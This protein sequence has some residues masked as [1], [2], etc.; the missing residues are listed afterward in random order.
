V[1]SGAQKLID[2]L[3]AYGL[4][5]FVPEPELVAFAWEVELGPL[6]GEQIELAFRAP[7]DF[8]LGAPGGLLVRPHLLALNPAGGEHP[9][10]GVHPA[11][12]CGVAD[13]SWQY[14]SRPHPNWAGTDR[15]VPALMA[16]VRHLFDTLP[17]DLRLTDGA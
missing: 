12:G 9:L 7:A 13:P 11:A 6:A 17:S 16:H 14:W 15:T 5:P 3:R 10:C 1:T 4:E 8:N 2:G